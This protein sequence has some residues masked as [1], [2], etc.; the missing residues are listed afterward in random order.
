M[1]ASQFGA[2]PIASPLARSESKI[3][4]VLP[5][6]VR[7]V[8]EAA[9]A[10]DGL[11]TAVLVMTGPKGGTKT[12]S[13]Q[14][15]ISFV[16]GRD[17]EGAEIPLAVAVEKG[18]VSGV[19]AARSTSRLVV[20]GD[21]LVF[22]NSA[23]KAA[24]GNRQFAALAISWLLDRSQALAIGPRPIQEYRL[25]L[26]A[27]NMRALWVAMTGVLPGAVLAVGAFVWLRRRA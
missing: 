3:I 10:S 20:V 23:M 1:L 17:V 16:P 26:T 11:K 14:G 15:E 19:N 4:F 7:P 22:A 25:D 21:S 27:K 5:G 18:G 8:A 9:A 13:P 24:S 12:L 2:H 6:V